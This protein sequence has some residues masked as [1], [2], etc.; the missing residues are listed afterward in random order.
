MEEYM[1]QPPVS[2]FAGPGARARALQ[3]AIDQAG[4]ERSATLGV[5][6]SVE[7]GDFEFTFMFRAEAEGDL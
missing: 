4:D 7:S 3:Q 6:D 5:T 1:T 2:S